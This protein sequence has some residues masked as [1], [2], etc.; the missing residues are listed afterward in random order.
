[1]VVV[2]LSTESSVCV[3]KKKK[4]HFR[5][6]IMLVV[7]EMCFTLA[8][9]EHE[10]TDSEALPPKPIIKK[11]MKTKQMETYQHLEMGSCCLISHT[12]WHSGLTHSKQNKQTKQKTEEREKKKQLISVASECCAPHWGILTLVLLSGSG[13]SS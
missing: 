4:N 7:P 12:F 5:K 1:M 9:N 6:R 3:T 10:F 8:T 13:E 11:A 2:W